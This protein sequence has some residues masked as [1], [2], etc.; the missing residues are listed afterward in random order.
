MPDSILGWLCFL[1]FIAWVVV[2]FYIGMSDK[3]KYTS[4]PGPSDDAWWPD[5]YGR[6]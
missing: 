3:T 5:W 6:K 2:C 4:D 1:F